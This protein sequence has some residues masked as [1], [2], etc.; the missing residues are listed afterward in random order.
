LKIID[1]YIRQRFLQSFFLIILILAVLFSF[2]EFLS[3]LDDV[4][5]GDYRLA[6]AVRYVALTLPKRL[7][8]L[9]PISTLL[10]GIIA[11][12]M[13]ADGNEL[14]GMQASG[15]SVRRIS[16][17]VLGAG[18]LLMVG[19]GVLA[20]IAVPIWEQEAR[21]AR[22]QA[23]AGADVTVVRQGFW[24]RR[25]TVFIHVDQ[26]LSHGLAADIDIFEFN[27]NGRL[28]RLIQA[29]SAD[30]GDDKQWILHGVSM[31]QIT[32]QGFSS[33]EV[34]S[35]T[36]DSF[37]SAEQI[38]LLTLPPHSLSTPDLTRYIR[39]LDESGQ[40][41]APYSLALWRKLGMPL[42][43]GAMVLF[44]LSF[45]FGSTRSQ[46]AGYRITIGAF[47]GISLY[48]L[49]RLS[50]NLGLLLNIPPW[51]TAMV[52]VVVISGVAFWRL[53]AVM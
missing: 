43:T 38:D 42:T 19:A 45:I 13:L 36:L 30:I 46:S 12:G 2:F 22:A 35:M 51:V 32:E 39:A 41:V 18:L 27:S 20:E 24:A 26:M 5:R 52:P 40:S 25:K 6:D 9:M 7:L 21:N 28:E 3:Q 53:R 47:V 50:V 8:D 16:I 17:S 14:L 1:R 49:D 34:P 15:I 33:T 48:L 37:L 4:G 29:R 44:C 23:I 11:L 31:K 10:G